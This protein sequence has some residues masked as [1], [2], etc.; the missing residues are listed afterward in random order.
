MGRLLAALVIIAI[1]AAPAMAQNQGVKQGIK[2][3][4]PALTTPQLKIKQLPKNAVAPQPGQ[5][6]SVQGTETSPETQQPAA[7][8]QFADF[9]FMPAS[10]SGPACVLKWTV[11]VRNTGTAATG[12]LV[13]RPI[14]R[15]AAGVNESAWQDILI[16]PL[17]AGATEAHVGFVPMREHEEA[18]VV[19]ELRDGNNLLASEVFPLPVSV[20]PSSE[21]LALNDATISGEWMSFT[22]RNTSNNDVNPV[23]YSIRGIADPAGQASEQLTSGIIQCVPA[24]GGAD[25]RANITLAPYPAY[26]II[27]FTGSVTSP[28]VE[29]TFPRP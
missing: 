16:G 10:Q 14:Y 28:L 12:N 2:D 17:A 1:L 29:R 24:G 18:E 22:V 21:N 4:V 11:S 20:R 15:K 6:G 19:L 25:V 26:R 7:N 13:L 5:T 27:L 3:N 8:V 9:R 23:N